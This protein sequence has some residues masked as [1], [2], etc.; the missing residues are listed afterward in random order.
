MSIKLMQRVF[1]DSTLKG[2]EKLL[3]LAIADNCNDTGVAFPSWN[4][5]MVKTSMSKG[6]VSKWLKSLELRNLLFR[7]NRKRKN[8]SNT[9]NKFLIYPIE[10]RSILDEEDFDLFESNY[11]EYDKIKH[12][13][14][15]E[16]ELGSRVQKLNQGSSEVE[17]PN[18]EQSSEVEPL[19]PLLNINH[20]LNHH[21]KEKTLGERTIDF[22]NQTVSKKFK[23]TKGNLKEI[24]SQ[25]NKGATEEELAHV[26][27]VKSNE[28]LTN[29]EMKKHLNPITL[30][31]ESNFDRYLNQEIV[32][33]EEQKMDMYL[34]LSGMD[35]C[36]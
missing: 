29:D 32:Y 34:K 12:N 24:N 36:Q 16:V 10:N 23:Y 22:L 7:K 13:Q 15:S 33:T 4:S 11:I 21:Y 2:N 25:I 28:W 19:E 17:L 18:G 6:S 27:L 14:S 35:T 31:R 3:L 1:N 30:F 8:G 20:H 26:I 9:S 5:L